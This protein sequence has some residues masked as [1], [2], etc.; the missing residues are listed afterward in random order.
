[1]AAA[2]PPPAASRIP[3]REDLNPLHIAQLQFDLAADHLKLDTDLRQLLRT[4]RRVLEVSLPVKLDNGQVRVY[5]AGGCIT[6]PA[7]DPPR[8][9][10]GTIPMPRW[11][12]SRHWPPG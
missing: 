5:T 11:T 2:V 8:V 6:T 10:F 4:P 1:M 3:P 12:K 9:G 7:A